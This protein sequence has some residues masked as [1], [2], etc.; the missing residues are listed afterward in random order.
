MRLG[1]YKR[2]STSAQDS[3]SQ[4]HAIRQW[5]VDH[6]QYTDVVEYEDAGMSGRDDSRP[7]FQAL[8]AA[9]RAG[10]V[11]AVVVYRLDRLSRNAVTALRLLL[12][13][14]TADVEFF[15][16]D[17]PILQLGRENPMRLT[18]AA[19]FSEFAQLEHQAIVARVRAGLAAAQA[20]GVKLGAERKLSDEAVQ[21]A[22]DMQQ[23][24]RSVRAIASEFGVSAATVSRSLRREN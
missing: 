7:Q 8:Q 21:A 6:P 4:D 10:E 13:W 22:R 17:T 2:V 11:Q 15:A 12:E 24:G 16:I 18:I 1:V 20:R 5:L 3:D 19:M 9:V 14:L 23:S